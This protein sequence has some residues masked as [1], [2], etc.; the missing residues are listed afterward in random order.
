MKKQAF[1]LWILILALLAGCFTSYSP[2]AQLRPWDAAAEGIIPYVYT[3]SQAPSPPKSYTIMV[4]LNGSDLETDHRAATIDLME[5][6]Q[7]GFDEDEVNVIVFTGGTRRWHLS[8]IPNKKN[9]IFQLNQDA[10]TRLANVGSASMGDPAVLAGFVNFCK[11]YYPAERHGL[12]LWNHG[13]GAIQGFG[14]DERY[15]EDPGRAMMKLRDIHRA[16]SASVPEHG[17]EFL[18]FDTCLMATLEMAAIARPYARFLIASQ[19]LEPVD[20]WDY[21]FLGHI[22]PGDT[23]AQIGESIIRHYEAFYQGSDFH[24]LLTLSLVD[25]AKIDDVYRAFENLAR[26][27]GYALSNGGFP[28]VA[29][30]RANTRSFGGEEGAGTDMVDLGQLAQNLS[31]ISPREARVLEEALAAA[32]IYQYN[33][34]PGR[35]GGLSVYFP[36]SNKEHLA[37]SIVVYK[38]MDQLPYY[39]RLLSRFAHK[40]ETPPGDTPGEIAITR[41]SAWTT[42]QALGIN[43]PAEAHFVKLLGE[44]TEDCVPLSLNGRPVFAYEITRSREKIR[45]AIPLHRNGKE[46]SLL[47]LFSRGETQ[48]QIIGTVPTGEDV[49]NR[50]DK[51]ILTLHPGDSLTPRYPALSM[52]AIGEISPDPLWLS[53]QPF[54][55]G[56]V[57][58]V[59]RNPA[60]PLRYFWN[61]T[62][63]QGNHHYVETREFFENN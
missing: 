46:E 48:G 54:S 7:S 12:I 8:F 42:P 38:E 27:T 30:A 41:L 34:Y 36:F 29:K 40:L 6:M 35:L 19:E 49:F 53:G 58:Q 63:I 1:L 15:E 9:T 20:G 56:E 3:S 2:P 21:A 47:A 44:G 33:D 4:Y 50:M 60:L 23:G 5:M 13:G 26:G 28:L 17:L 57:L 31:S 32:V 22:K 16:L 52:A 10:M 39:T 59:E 62:D 37:H 18:G 43:P 61:H 25:L 45:Y 14:H 51:K 11:H 24:H 55:I